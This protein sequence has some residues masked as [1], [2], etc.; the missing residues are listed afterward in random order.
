MRKHVLAFLSIFG[1]AG[2]STPASAQ[3]VKGSQSANTKSESTIK[4][5]KAAQE[6][7]AGQ[8]AANITV[9]KAGGEQ[10]AAKDDASKKVLIGLSQPAKDDAGKKVRKAGGEQNAAKND[11]SK[12]VLIGLSQPSKDDSAAKMRKAGGEQQEQKAGYMKLE[13]N[14]SELKATRGAAEYKEQKALGDGSVKTAT[15]TTAHGSGG[16]AGKVAMQ[17]VHIK[18]EKSAAEAK[19][20]QQDAAKKARKEVNQASPK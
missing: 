15:G 17:D 14:K 13:K 6:S 20:V 19:A 12:K 5:S 3:V 18:G 7:T 11:A 2:S 9:R 16:G 1:L 10:N 4:A 8:G